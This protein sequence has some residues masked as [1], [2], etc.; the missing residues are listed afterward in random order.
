MQAYIDI[1]KNKEV[2]F[3]YRKKD[4]VFSLSHGLFSSAE[5][6]T[7]SHFLL[8][9]FSEYLDECIKNSE[10]LPQKILD[11][12]SGI[13]VLGICAA[14]A[15][16]DT[17]GFE[18]DKLEIKF[19]DR[20]ELAR[21]FTIN[22]ALKNNI[23]PN[24]FSAYT[25]PLLAG[26]KNSFWDLIISNIPAK[27]GLPVLEDFVQRSR[28]ILSEKGR[29]F[30]VVVNP[31]A[32]FFET[33]IKKNA[34]LLLCEKT[35]G[36]TVF[37]YKRDL[38][39][40]GQTLPCLLKERF[41]TDCPAYIRNKS[42]FEIEKISYN[43]ETVHGASGFDNPGFDILTAAKLTK[44]LGQKIFSNKDKPSILVWSEDQ[45]HF[46]SWFSAYIKNDG[47]F[48]KNDIR[49]IVSGRNILSLVM[50]KYNT[51]NNNQKPQN[52]IYIHC[53]ADIYLD[54]EI[55]LE[56]C[57]ETGFSL[58][59]YFPEIVPGTKFA[60]TSWE[61]FET[62]LEPGSIVIIAMASSEAETFDRKKTN[63]F[64][65]LGDIKRKGF[66]ACAYCKKSNQ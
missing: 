56:K 50:A 3:K 21:I 59:A 51:E 29:A 54:K 47:L 61:S 15:V 22:N 49:L 19:Q 43:M 10:P 35:K 12:G 4:Y 45:G 25:E 17:K 2:K 8:K 65:R 23:P 18:K 52:K 28:G 64:T 27:A 5:I 40:S 6:D 30:I 14:T 13:G 42:K 48:I 33:M 7:G 46:S 31:L 24:N 36:H 55:L 44:K 37:V 63:A 34:A 39:K 32:L 58:I 20:D 9:V 1:Y 62:L 60:E 53:A 41:Y 26:S 66:R 38:E 11:A 16:S 57:G